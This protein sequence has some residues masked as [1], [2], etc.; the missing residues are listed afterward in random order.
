MVA[1][2]TRVNRDLPPYFLYGG[3]NVAPRGI[4]RVGLRRAG[5]SADD[6]AAIKS[7]YRLLYRSGLALTEALRRIEEEIVAAPAHDIVAFIRSSERG[8]CRP[9]TAR[10]HT[11]SDAA[12]E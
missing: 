2:I 5:F 4:N 8:I 9:R 7:A 6:I 10:E 1:G 11:D 3:F 12:A